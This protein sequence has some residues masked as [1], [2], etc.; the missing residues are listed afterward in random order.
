MRTAGAIIRYWKART[1]YV[2]LVA[3]AVTECMNV[4]GFRTGADDDEIGD[5]EVWRIWQAIQLDA[6]AGLV[7]DPS[8]VM[9]ESY[10]IVGPPASDDGVP[11]LCRIGQVRPLPAGCDPVSCRSWVSGTPERSFST[12]A[13]TRPTTVKAAR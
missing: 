9:S 12:K 3:D 1:N 11:R 4:V 5:A 8:V 7:H 10:A 13:T 6:D 2:G